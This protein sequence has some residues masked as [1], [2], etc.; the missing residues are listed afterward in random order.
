MIVVVQALT[1]VFR[2]VELEAN[3]LLDT[4]G[5]IPWLAGSCS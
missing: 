5:P 4:L 1:I 2:C 3:T